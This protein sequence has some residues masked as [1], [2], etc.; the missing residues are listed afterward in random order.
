MTRLRPASLVLL[1]HPVSHSLSPAF[2]NAALRAASIPLVYEAVDVA[3]DDLARLV[4]RLRDA[5]AAGNVTIPHKEHFAA[6]CD[7]RTPEAERAA[8]VNTFWV[9]EGLLVGHNTDIAGFAAAAADLLGRAPSGSRIALLGAGGAAA[10]VLC[11]SEAWASSRVALYNRTRSRAEALADRFSGLCDI[12]DS[13]KDAVRGASL[14]VNATPIGLHDDSLPVPVEA[15]DHRSAVLDLVYRPGET[16]FVR[17]ARAREL[18]AADGRGMLIEQGALAFE[19][20]F[21]IEPDREAMRKALES[22]G[23]H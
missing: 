5:G 22:A 11:A 8:A 14:V 10:A 15:L 3:P 16:A 1:G 19:R 12:A 21:G 9:E 7:A 13:A 18:R 23:S 17:A 6:F 2:Q 20:W 4:R